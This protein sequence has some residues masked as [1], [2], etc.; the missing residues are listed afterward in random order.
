VSD[1]DDDGLT[2]VCRRGG[3]LQHLVVFQSVE[4]LV[5]WTGG[6]RR[7]VV[8][9]N[10]TIFRNLVRST[11]TFKP[12]ASAHFYCLRT[13]PIPQNHEASFL[14]KSTVKLRLAEDIATSQD[15]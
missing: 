13:F 8:I 9:V 5:D 3:K 7:R 11:N 6:L 2:L 12:H 10:M 14:A 4:V 15:V 1:I